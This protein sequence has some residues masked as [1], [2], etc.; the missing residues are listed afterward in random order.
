MRL[1]LGLLLVVRAFELWIHDND[2]RQAVGLPPSVPD[3]ST[4]SLMTQAAARLK[5][6]TWT[7][8]MGSGE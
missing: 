7:L 4:L 5:P 6:R 8:S 3:P 2:I 1:P